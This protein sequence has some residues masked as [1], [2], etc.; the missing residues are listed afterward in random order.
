MASHRIVSYPKSYVTLDNLKKFSAVPFFIPWYRSA[1]SHKVFPIFLNEVSDLNCVNGFIPGMLGRNPFF[2]H[3][4]ITYFMADDYTHFDRLAGRIAAFVDERYNSEH[5]EKTGWIGMFE[6]VESPALGKMLLESAIRHLK[7]KGCTKVIGPAKFNANGEVGLLVDGFQ[8][9]PYFMEAYNAPYYPE[10]F[11]SLGFEKEN[12]W[13]SI[14]ILDTGSERL[15]EYMSRVEMMRQKATGSTDER[16]KALRNTTIRPS[17]L[18]QFNREMGIIKSLYNSEWGKGSHPQ[19]VSMTD[20]EF[21]TLATGIKLIALED[22]ILIAELE[23]KPVGV[24]VT[25]P[26][27]NE[28]IAEHDRKNPDYLPSGNFL[29]PADLYRDASILVDIKKRLMAKRFDSLR[30]LILGVKEEYRKSGIDAML[31]HDS[32]KNAMKI[33]A[34]RASFSELADINLDILTPLQKMGDLAMTWRVYSLGI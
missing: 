22:L 1:E 31:Y 7:E 10:Y 5:S 15:K 17:Q 34:R 23:D 19:F 18:S 21:K 12:D 14:Q 2:E 6:C 33:G 27:I 3:A 29:D 32:F 25:V 8:Y 20:N 11:E 9:D 28:V 13:Y 4:D 30:V 26:N 24:S 16:T